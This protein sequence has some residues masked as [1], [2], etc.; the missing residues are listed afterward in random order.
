MNI[1]ELF[2]RI[3]Y[4]ISVPK[5]VYCG[6]KLEYNERGL[7][8][9]CIV[10][11]EQHKTR[12]CSRCSKILSECSCSSSY[13]SRHG[14]KSLIKVFRYSKSEEAMPSNFL[15]YSLKQDNR[16]DVLSLV[17][18]ELSNSLRQSI[19]FGKGRYIITNVP[20]RRKS[21]VSFG[22]DHAQLLARRTAKLIGCEYVSLLVSKSKRAQKSVYGSARIE[23]AQFDYKRRKGI[24]LKGYC[25]ILVDDIVTT[26]ASMSGCADLLKK[27]GARRIIGASLAIAFKDSY[28]PRR[29]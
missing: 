28:T 12:N 17:A 3:I 19:D 6:K 7:C 11:Y 1:N 27:M 9:E 5:C 25:V 4:Y 15:I 22:F 24:S 8:S 14:V 18:E 29:R 2:K 13:L 23:N 21:I 26:G 16:E 20:R 10:K